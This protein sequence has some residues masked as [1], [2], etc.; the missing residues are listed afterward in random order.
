[1]RL[2]LTLSIAGNIALC[3]AAVWLFQQNQTK[4]MPAKSETSNT[5]ARPIAAQSRIQSSGILQ[6]SQLS[7]DDLPTYVASLRAI[8]CPPS[9]VR[10]IIVARVNRK[11]A[12]SLD[13]RSRESRIQKAEL[14]W[15]P[16]MPTPN[17]RKQNNPFCEFDAAHRDLI[18]RLLGEDWNKDIRY[19]PREDRVLLNFLPNDRLVSLWRAAQGRPWQSVAQKPSAEVQRILSPAELEELRLRASDTATDKRQNLVGFEPTEDEFRNI[20][21]VREASTNPANSQAGSTPPQNNL[22]NTIGQER[23]A[24]L[25]RADDLMFR[26]LYV[27]GRHY[28]QPPQSPVNAYTAAKS[29]EAKANA[30]RGDNTLSA[31]DKAAALK[32]NR[33][34]TSDNLLA[35]LG[36]ECFTALN[37]SA[38]FWLDDLEKINGGAK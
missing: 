1:M 14:D 29:G 38:S 36:A 32:Q 7:P 9:T 27:F 22:I 18:T 37:W 35:S 10:D 5:P 26:A 23:F 33:K 17:P 25:E 11:F 6:W 4:P 15:R 2:F 8:G 28:N 16:P 31:S 34:R 24:E 12:E 19:V 3:G 20:V 13:G 30:I 21:R